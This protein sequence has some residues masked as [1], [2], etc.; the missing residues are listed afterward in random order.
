MV[1]KYRRCGTACV[2]CV[3]IFSLEIFTLPTCWLVPFSNAISLWMMLV[4][5]QHG[6]TGFNFRWGF[7]KCII[8]YRICWVGI[9]DTHVSFFYLVFSPFH[10]MVLRSFFVRLIPLLLFLSFKCISLPVFHNARNRRF[11]AYIY[12]HLADS[13]HLAHRRRATHIRVPFACRSRDLY[14]LDNPATIHTCIRG[15][16]FLLS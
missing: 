1:W 8:V 15:R 13:R 9:T 14:C 2:R 4:R 11:D 10:G 12:P 16:H 5:W 7:D 6:I 3:S